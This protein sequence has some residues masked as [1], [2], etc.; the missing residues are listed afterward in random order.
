MKKHIFLYLATASLTSILQASIISPWDATNLGDGFAAGAAYGESSTI[1]YY[2]PAGIAFIPHQ[3]LSF[4]LISDSV[5]TSFKGS[6][7]I[8]GTTINVPTSNGNDAAVYPNIAYSA[9]IGNRVAV[10]FS[11]KYDNVN[12]VNFG[13]QWDDPNP[14]F[15]LTNFDKQYSLTLQPTLAIK[16][17]KNLSIGVGFNAIYNY[18]K[19][20]VNMLVDPLTFA[21]VTFKADGW[22]YNWNVG[23]DWHINDKSAIGLSYRGQSNKIISGN[24]SITT[25]IVTTPTTATMQ[26]RITAFTPSQLIASGYTALTSKLT[27]LAS[28]YY[29]FWSNLKHITVDGKVNGS[30]SVDFSTDIKFKN[31]LNFAFGAHYA[32]TKKLMA[33]FGLG[34]TDDATKSGYALLSNPEIKGFT[35]SAGDRKSVV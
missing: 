11:T 10:G 3:S 21:A 14:L 27:V 12:G 22:S 6:T 32:F 33:K 25:I 2:N 34:Y 4:G 19:N 9:P 1:Q 31:T 18:N 29:S 20:S 15:F 16:I 13:N 35:L 7:N 17:I 5:S 23:A 30:P 24:G 8:S 28:A 26:S